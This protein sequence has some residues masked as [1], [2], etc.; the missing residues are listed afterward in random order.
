M[1]AKIKNYK[2]LLNNLVSVN[3]DDVFLGSIE[4]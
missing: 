2:I 3:I 4:K 1:I